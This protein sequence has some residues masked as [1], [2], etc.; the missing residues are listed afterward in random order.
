MLKIDIRDVIP[1]SA[2][3]KP[4][5]ALQ[6]KIDARNGG[7]YGAI[8]RVSFGDAADG[9]RFAAPRFPSRLGLRLVRHPLGNRQIAFGVPS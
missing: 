2:F 7:G 1:G 8:R 6:S 4:A 3:L 9:G 5:T